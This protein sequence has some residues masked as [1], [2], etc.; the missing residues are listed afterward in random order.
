MGFCRK[1]KEKVVI[2]YD[3]ESQNM[4]K[5]WK[6]G[7]K[8]GKIISWIVWL[9]IRFRAFFTSK[10]AALMSLRSRAL[11]T[12]NCSALPGTYKKKK[13]PKQNR[14]ESKQ[15]AQKEFYNVKG[16]T[17]SYMYFGNV[18]ELL[19]DKVQRRIHTNVSVKIRK[20]LT[21][22]VRGHQFLIDQQY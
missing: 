2:F 14:G 1:A 9:T 17:N 15:Q 6:K 13:S 10:K 12:Q 20:I 11:T 3:L 19:L 21:Q 4:Q 22:R 8:R 7:G 5:E 18:A 16:Y